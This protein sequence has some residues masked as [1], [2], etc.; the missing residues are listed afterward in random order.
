MAEPSSVSS[1]ILRAAFSFFAVFSSA[2]PG[3]AQMHSVPASLPSMRSTPL[4]HT[5]GVPAPVTSSGAHPNNVPSCR[6]GSDGP[7]TFGHPGPGYGHDRHRDRIIPI[8]YTYYP[9]IPAPVYPG[10]ESSQNTPPQVS[11]AVQSSD[12]HG[13]LESEVQQ[14]RQELADLK[15]SQMLSSRIEAVAE[16]QV[17][18]QPASEPNTTQSQ[19]SPLEPNAVLVLHDARTVELYNYLIAGGS[20]WNLVEERMERIP[21]D[22]LDVEETREIN[23]SRG[24]SRNASAILDAVNNNVHASTR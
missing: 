10:D 6:R 19:D 4:P 16:P 14:L 2:V 13:A 11:S 23:E 21:L 15:E 22:D 17:A 24:L 9:G 3:A 7:R 1:L 8:V 12:Q 20:I 5:M 18:D